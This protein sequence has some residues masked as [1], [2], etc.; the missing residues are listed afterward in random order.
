LIYDKLIEW[1]NRYN[2]NSAQFIEKI[3][4]LPTT[5]SFILGTITSGFLKEI[6][7]EVW[8][9]LKKIFISEDENKRMPGFEF[10]FIYE[11]IEIIA[12]LESDAPQEL[13]KALNNLNGIINKI[14]DGEEDVGKMRFTL[15]SDG[16]EWKRE[17]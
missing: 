1:D 2:K 16:G 9:N 6:G 4:I 11:G 10:N 7:K 3:D 12:E 15:D 17:E 5:I 8:N 14:L 13:K